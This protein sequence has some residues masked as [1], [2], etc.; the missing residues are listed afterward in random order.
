MGIALS[1]NG[2]MNTNYSENPH[3]GFG[4][5][6]HAGVDLSQMFVSPAVAADAQRI[7]YDAVKSIGTPLQ[8][9]VDGALRGADD[10]P[11]FGWRAMMP[12]SVAWQVSARLRVSAGYSYC[13]QSVPQD[14]TLANMLAPGVIEE[15]YAAGRRVHLWI[16][17]G[18]P[19][20]HVLHLC[21]QGDGSRTGFD[22]AESPGQPVAAGQFRRR[23]GRC[24]S[25]RAVARAGD[26]LSV[27]GSVK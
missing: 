7:R 10:G 2:G 14:Q 18:V 12:R 9:F 23:R 6:G 24:S 21:T 22:S 5:S 26:R 15:H 13:G 17:K 20:E 19:R 4:A 11:G 16:C 27:R 8:P 1:G 25:E 3:G